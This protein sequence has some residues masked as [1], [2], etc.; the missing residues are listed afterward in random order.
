[1]L[2]VL[3]V[4]SHLLGSFGAGTNTKLPF[5]GGFGTV[6]RYFHPIDEMEYAI[7]KIRITNKDWKHLFREVRLLARLSHPHIIRYFHSWLEMIES[8]DHDIMDGNVSIEGSDSL[9]TASHL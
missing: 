2:P 3:A 6:Y 5:S 8:S 1:M 9:T 7:K 4:A